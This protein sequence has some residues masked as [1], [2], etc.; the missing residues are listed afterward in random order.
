MLKQMDS[1]LIKKIQKQKYNINIIKNLLNK[2]I[3]KQ[4]CQSF[5]LRRYNN[6][7]INQYNQF[8][9]L[10][11]FSTALS[12]YNNS[13][14]SQIKRLNIQMRHKIKSKHLKFKSKRIY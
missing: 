11:I 6:K 14:Y 9:K 13:Q 8:Q 3:M 1:K 2:Q 5:K 4:K 7:I 10:K 12:I